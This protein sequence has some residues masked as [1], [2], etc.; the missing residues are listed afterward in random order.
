MLKRFLSSRQGTFDP[1][2]DPVSR[3]DR[4]EECSVC[5][6]YALQYPQFRKKIAQGNLPRKPEVSCGACHDAHIVAPSGIDPAI[7]TS[8]VVVTGLTGTS[9]VVSV[10]AVPGRSVSYINNKPYPIADS[11]AMDTNQRNMD[12]G[13]CDKP[14]PDNSHKRHMRGC[15]Y[16]WGLQFDH[17]GLRPCAGGG[18]FLKNQVKAEDTIFISGVAST[19]VN[20]PAD[21]K[22]A[23]KAITL[24]AT[25]DRAGFQVLQ[26][27]DD[28]TILVDP[29]VTASTNVTYIQTDGKTTETLSVT[30]PSA[31][32]RSTLRSGICIPIQRTSA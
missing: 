19:T 11:G 13:L 21:A 10:A 28:K 27:I 23:G 20:L 29:P 30:F 8:T 15:Q 26:V 17:P 22:L 3:N 1:L 9:T 24:E 7:V 14:A 5:H 18:G 2:G 4:I 6:Q 12:P 25:L 31:A 16:R 32:C